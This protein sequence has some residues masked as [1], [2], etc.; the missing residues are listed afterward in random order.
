MFVARH[1]ERAYMQP[2]VLLRI[3]ED[4]KHMAPNRSWDDPLTSEGL[5]QAMVL[6]RDL[7]AGA[8]RGVV[9]S[10]WLRCAQTAAVVAQVLGVPLAFDPALGE[11]EKEEWFVTAGLPGQLTRPLPELLQKLGEEA[12]VERML[13]PTS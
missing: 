3:P 4:D 2:P 12:R 7:P 10:N 13:A 9:A 5:R 6:A 8:V 1:A 11:F